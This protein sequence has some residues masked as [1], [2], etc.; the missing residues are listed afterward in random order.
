MMLDKRLVKTYIDGYVTNGVGLVLMAV[1]VF[2]LS[3]GFD[4]AFDNE[5]NAIRS[6]EYVLA[7][8]L[9][10]LVAD[11]VMT[12]IA[13][14]HV[15]LRRMCGKD[16]FGRAGIMAQLKPPVLVTFIREHVAGY[17]AGVFFVLLSF[18]VGSGDLAVYLGVSL[19]ALIG[20]FIYYF[21]LWM[22]FPESV[23]GDW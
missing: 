10:I 13:I 6:I 14:L 12:L 20:A 19:K 21:A 11:L 1:C 3:Y 2:V 23:F 8:P 17:V 22:Y 18:Y 9:M 15:L 16:V 4:V 5:R 7:I